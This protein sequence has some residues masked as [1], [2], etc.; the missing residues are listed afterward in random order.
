MAANLELLLHVWRDS[1]PRAIRHLIGCGILAIL[2]ALT[3]VLGLIKSVPLRQTVES[4][5]NIHFLFELFL[6]WLVIARYRW[7]G[8][9]TAPGTRTEIKELSRHLSRIVYLVLYGV[10]GLRE[11]IALADGLLNGGTADFATFQDRLRNG[12]DSPFFDLQ[13]DFQ[14]FFASGLVA[15]GSVRAFMFRLWLRSLA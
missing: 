5:I 3:G 9:R 1:R 15:L 4:W 7:C 2:T 10:I 13:D 12:P 6:G 11:I 14:V 8:Q